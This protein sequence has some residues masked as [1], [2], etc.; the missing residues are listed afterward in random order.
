M[1]VIGLLNP[2]GSVAAS[3]SLSL[4]PQ[5]FLSVIVCTTPMYMLTLRPWWW[6]SCSSPLRRSLHSGHDLNGPH[7]ALRRKPL[8]VRHGRGELE[9]VAVR[10][11]E[12][13]QPAV[14]GLAGVV[15]L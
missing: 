7:A 13:R 11:G 1:K 10:V 15:G 9:V 2:S 14:G 4:A 3:N 12:R 8:H 6:C 5:V